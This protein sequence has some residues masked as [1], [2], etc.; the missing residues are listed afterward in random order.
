MITN[1]VIK[2]LDIHVFLALLPFVDCVQSVSR[3][4]RIISYKAHIYS[5]SER[6]NSIRFL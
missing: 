2:Y 4:N 3:T 1:V 5:Q 6:D